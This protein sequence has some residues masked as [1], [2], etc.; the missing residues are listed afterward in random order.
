MFE[1]SIVIFA[2]AKN[3]IMTLSRFVTMKLVS[4]IR[5]GKT[6]TQ[7]EYILVEPVI[8]WNLMSFKTED[9]YQNLTCK[10]VTVYPFRI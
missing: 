6:E 8:N 9:Q 5:S 2:S 3:N 7:E 10:V 1:Y 4:E